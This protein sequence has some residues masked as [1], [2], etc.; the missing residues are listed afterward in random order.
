LLESVSAHT[1]LLP[2]KAFSDGDTNMQRMESGQGFWTLL[3]RDEREALT[4]LGRIRAFPAGATMC[5]EGEPT[6]HVFVLVT[7]WVKVLAV[8]NDGRELMLALRGQGDVVGEISGLTT[9]HRNATVKA[10]D[11]V[12]ALLVQYDRFGSFLDSHPGADRAYRQVM[13]LRWN[14]EARTLRSRALTTGAQ[15]L[16][17][18][19]LDLTDRYGSVANGTKPLPLSQE[20]LASLAGTSR[21]T[22]TRAFG[23]WRRRGLVRT[24]Q[25]RITIL[26][27]AGL[28]RVAGSRPSPRPGPR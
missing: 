21:A 15:R 22:V 20:E 1:R 14:D 4:T 18:L 24:G 13:T 9:G 26:D 16:A 28:Q 3:S 10:V 6:T 27:L 19:L 25:R 5:S 7:G 11:T 17:L 2:Y 23:N 12:R 8:T